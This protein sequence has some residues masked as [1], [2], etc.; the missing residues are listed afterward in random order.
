MNFFERLHHLSKTDKADRLPPS[1]LYSHLKRTSK[2]FE[3][4]LHTPYNFLPGS[5]TGFRSFFVGRKPITFL[6]STAKS[7]RVMKASIYQDLIDGTQG[8]PGLYNSLYSSFMSTYSN[9]GDNQ[10]RWFIDCSDIRLDL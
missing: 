10:S 3:K 9:Q 4:L 5:N 8:V 1:I 7:P 2:E 6:M